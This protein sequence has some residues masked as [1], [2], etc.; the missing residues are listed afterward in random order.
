MSALYDSAKEERKEQVEGAA[1]KVN[2]DENYD[3]EVEDEKKVA[4]SGGGGLGSGRDSPRGMASV[5]GQ[6]KP[7]GISA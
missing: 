5:A 7:E 1:R 4:L 6:P 2:V 3:D